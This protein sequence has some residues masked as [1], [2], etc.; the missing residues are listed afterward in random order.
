MPAPGGADPRAR[1]RKVLDLAAVIRIGPELSK[2]EQE[3]ARA[4][5]A[6]DPRLQAALGTAGYGLTQTLAAAPQRVGRW[7]D[8]QAADPYAWAVLTAAMDTARLGA[9]GRTAPTS[10]TWWRRAT[11]PPGNWQ[12]CWWQASN[13]VTG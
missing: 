3:R 4:A 9:R 11:A 2:A 1:E 7:E 6:R 10:C 8:A 13:L 5:A 12:S